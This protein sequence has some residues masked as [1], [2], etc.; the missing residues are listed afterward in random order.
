MN[1]KKD[2]MYILGVGLAAVSVLLMVVTFVLMG[3]GSDPSIIWFFIGSIGLVVS[4]F[5]LVSVKRKYETVFEDEPSALDIAK[6]NFE[7]AKE[8]IFKKGILG[9]VLLGVLVASFITT[10]VM[11]IVVLNTSYQKSGAINAGYHFNLREA[12][13]Y[14]QLRIEQ[15]EKGNLRFAAELEN[16][17]DKCIKESE[18]Y[19]SYYGEL[20]EK[21][22]SQVSVLI[23]MATVNGVILVIYIGFVLVK[24]R[25]EQRENKT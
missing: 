10:A 25:K 4:N 5:I 2:I 21:L 9:A 13:R 15:V 19:L 11:G 7:T 3:F 1:Y 24:K 14:E 16:N 6:D 23:I 12:E 17:R 8:K 20:T 18:W 22:S